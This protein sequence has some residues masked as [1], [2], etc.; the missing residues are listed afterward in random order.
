MT[1]LISEEELRAA[2]EVLGLGAESYA[3][4]ASVK[5]A[6]K[7]QAKKC[8]PDAGGSDEAMQ[9][10]NAAYET[11]MKHLGS[12]TG[13]KCICTSFIRN[14]MC[15][16]HEELPEREAQCSECGDTKKVET[17]PVWARLKM[18]CPKCTQ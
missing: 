10:L 16:A 18:D 17:G 5:I 7:E 15:K 14:S 4:K 8:H 6:Y 12:R 1:A 2:L 11:V 3:S 13:P 9:K